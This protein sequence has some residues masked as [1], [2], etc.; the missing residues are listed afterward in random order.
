VIG[1]RW[2]NER[3]FSME[4]A[5]EVLTHGNA[6]HRCRPAEINAR[7]VSESLQAA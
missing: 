7:I 4:A 3:N 5:F 1:Y 6:G 2:M